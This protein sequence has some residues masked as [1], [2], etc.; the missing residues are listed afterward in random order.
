MGEAARNDGGSNHRWA[1]S[2]PIIDP[3]SRPSPTTAASCNSIDSTRS[4]RGGKGGKE[5]EEEE[6]SGRRFW[7][8]KTEPSD[9]SWT[10]QAAAAGNGTA[11][12]DGVRNN[13]AWSRSAWSGWWRWSGG[14][15]RGTRLWR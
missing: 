8:L 10:E 15:P 11:L 5:A 4:P 1:C 3:V 7:L 6:D 2:R 9:W 12:W 13:Q 14:R